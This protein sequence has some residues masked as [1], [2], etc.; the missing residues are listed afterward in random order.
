MVGGLWRGSC[1]T[2]LASAFSLRQGRRLLSSTPLAAALSQRLESMRL[3]NEELVAELSS[4]SVPASRMGSLSKE[5]SS[6]SAVIETADI[7]DKRTTELHDLQEVMAASRQGGEAE[8][9]EMYAL[10]VEES[11]GCERTIGQLRDK[12]VRQLLPKDAADDRNVMVEVR[13][14]SGGDEAS[15]FAAEM[16]AM[17]QLFAASQG[18][19]F[20]LISVSKSSLKGYKEAIAQVS[21]DEVYRQLKYENGVHRVQRVP[22]NDVKMQT[23]AV[24]VVVIPEPEE[25]E[26]TLA[27]SDLKVETF[28][29]GG[30][31]GQHVNTTESAVRIMHIPSGIQVSIQDERSQ[32]MNR[33]KA[34]TILR[35]RIY[36]K[37]RLKAA[38]SISASRLESIGSGD[39]SERIRTYHYGQDRI[40][41]HRIGISKFGLARMMSTGEAV[42]EFSQPLQ[43]VEENAKIEALAK[44]ALE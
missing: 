19:N 27:P 34:M 7:L 25:V 4:G 2:S 41:D 13:A 12:L 29:A 42:S 38:D 24:S 17:Y 9:P 10:A 16:M 1:I 3:R 14:G 32:H 20:Q 18:W 30:A 15:L 6:A 40:T 31:G 22:V 23:S 8:D 43:E 5:L 39:R 26:V 33:S 35:S 21:G 36:E 44:E 11:E 37:E 28:R